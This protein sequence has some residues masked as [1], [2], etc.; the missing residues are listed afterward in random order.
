VEELA[1]ALAARWGADA[2]RAS[3]A[4]LV[5][6]CAKGLSLA[7]MK[8]LALAGGLR[9]DRGMRDS[10]A[11]LHAPVGAYLARRDYGVDDPAMLDAI[12]WHTTGR[13]SMAVL[14]KII[15]LADMIE[16]GRPAFEGLAV[17]RAA[18]WDDL[19]AAMLLALRGTAEYVK[20]RRNPLHSDTLEALRWLET[21]IARPSR[22]RLNHA[23]THRDRPLRR[24][25]AGR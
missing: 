18:V 15:Y 11:L 1:R 13:A 25:N 5:H 4:G 8:G 12:R 10:R 9:P 2:E 23:R 19:D 6:D 16:P 21:P 22:R 7:Q 17:L 3:R 24:P 20:K 14:E